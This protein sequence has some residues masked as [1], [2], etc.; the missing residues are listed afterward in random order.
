MGI[1]FV[2]RWKWGAA[3]IGAMRLLVVEDESKTARYLKRGS[4]ESGF[5]VGWQPWSRAEAMGQANP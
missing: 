1:A 2:S 5:A 3:E 4:T